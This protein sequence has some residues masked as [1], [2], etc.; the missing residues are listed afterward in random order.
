MLTNN[1]KH[2]IGLP[3]KGGK[4]VRLGIGETTEAD[5]DLDNEIVKQWLDL[6]LL[7]EGKPKTKAKAAAKTEAPAPP[8][9]KP[10]TA[11][12][13]QFGDY[14]VVDKDGAPYLDT[15]GNEVIFRSKDGDAEPK[16]KAYAT[17]LNLE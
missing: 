3:L 1:A 6:G 9:G 4:H 15:D 17:R 8:P 11:Q 2:P 12:H 5:I 7:S 10:Y 13:K 16:A 14:V